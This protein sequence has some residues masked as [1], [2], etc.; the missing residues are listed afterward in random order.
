MKLFKYKEHNNNNTSNITYKYLMLSLF[1][2]VICASLLCLTS[3]AWF[4]SATSS[5]V[6]SIISPTY[7]LSYMIDGD[8]ETVMPYAGLTTSAID[9]DLVYITLTATGTENAKGYCE[10]KVCDD[11]N[12]AY[13]YTNYITAN[14]SYS[15]TLTST[16][17]K[18]ITFIPHWGTYTTMQGEKKENEPTSITTSL[19]SFEEDD[20]AVIDESDTDV[21]TVTEDETSS[22]DVTINAIDSNSSS[23]SA[24][25][26]TENKSNV[27]TE[28]VSSDAFTDDAT[29]TD[30]VASGNS[31]DRGSHQST[32]CEQSEINET[33][34][35]T[36]VSSAE[37]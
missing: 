4:T 24:D 18:T 15:F 13:Y 16:N 31:T 23:D 35:S 33:E 32:N 25:T 11:T 34:Q 26:T 27:L 22:D 10:I 21:D 30:I 7:Y 36:D 9:R 1:S 3:Y 29:E 12:C 37:Q 2:V 28:D 6:S 17:A 20:I 8:T 14:S 5:S 19:Y